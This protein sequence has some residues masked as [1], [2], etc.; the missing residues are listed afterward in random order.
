MFQSRR[1]CDSPY[2]TS[3][4]SRPTA[5][6]ASSWTDRRRRPPPVIKPGEHAE[7]EHVAERVRHRDCPLQD[8][9]GVVLEVRLDQVDP[10]EQADA[11]GDDGRVEQAAA[12]VT[13]CAERGSAGQ[14]AANSGYVSRYSGSASDG[15]G[16]SWPTMSV[17]TLYVVSPRM[18]QNVAA[19]SRYHA[20]GCAGRR[21]RM[22]T[23]MAA[24]E[25]AVRAASTAGGD[26]PGTRSTRSRARHS[27]RESHQE[28]AT[29]E[30][31]GCRGLR[32]AALHALLPVI[33][34]SDDTPRSPPA[35]S[36]HPE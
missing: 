9:Q 5:P 10:H 29:R 20:P 16:L 31:A 8:R 3:A 21:S 13:R 34:R 14:P 22:P 26:G 15:Y 6:N 17:R 30:R 25:T 35:R 11:S 12:V 4:T 23:T 18:K 24:T 32:S 36:Q 27:R 33:A 28:R 19:A 2:R 1:S 7:H